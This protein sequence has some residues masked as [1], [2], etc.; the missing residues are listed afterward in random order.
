MA[1]KEA[2]PN[3]VS[4]DQ[5]AARIGGSRRSIPI[6]MVSLKKYAEKHGLQMGDLLVREKPPKGEKGSS[7]RLTVNGLKEFLGRQR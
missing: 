4:S 7:Y 1:L 2:F 3:G 5:L 6:I